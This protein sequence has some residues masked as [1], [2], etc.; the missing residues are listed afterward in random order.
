[1]SGSIKYLAILTLSVFILSGCSDSVKQTSSKT[2]KSESI[3]VATASSFKNPF[4]EIA[5]DFEKTTGINVDISLG[6]SGLLAKQIEEGAPIDVFA[7]AGEEFVDELENL[8]LV[9]DRKSLLVNGKLALVF[10]RDAGEKKLEGLS[11]SKIERIAIA[12]PEHAPYGKAA[13]EALE[14]AGL[15]DKVSSKIVYGNSVVEA[16]Q[17]LSSGNADAALVSLSEAI[18]GDFDYLIV[19]SALYKPINQPIVIIKDTGKKEAAESFINAI[20]SPK[21]EKILKKYGF[22]ISDE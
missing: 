7:S 12:N 17:F 9:S 20:D 8:G 4:T 15:W 11:G 1:M 3:T 14:K 18:T 21:G 13:K 16:F 6:S 10:G 22:E 19:D 5:A 2:I